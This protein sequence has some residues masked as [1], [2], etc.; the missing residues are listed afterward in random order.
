[1]DQ[2]QVRSRDLLSIYSEN[3][4]F[5][6]REATL[7]KAGYPEWPTSLGESGWGSNPGLGVG[8]ESQISGG[9]VEM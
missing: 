9:E 6:V 2:K 8:E 5:R 1:M 7:E 3:R 4:Y